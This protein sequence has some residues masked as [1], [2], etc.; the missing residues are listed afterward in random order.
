MLLSKKKE[1]PLKVQEPVCARAGV[2]Q[3]A[4]V[5]TA[6]AHSWVRPV[7]GA[8]RSVPAHGPQAAPV[9]APVPA[10]VSPGA[11]TALSGCSAR[12]PTALTASRG[13]TLLPPGTEHPQSP[14]EAALPPATPGPARPPGPP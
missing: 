3:P 7:A 2:A 13:R 1:N 4:Q 11:R 9:P 10:E 6:P 14:A 12:T 8:A 5:G